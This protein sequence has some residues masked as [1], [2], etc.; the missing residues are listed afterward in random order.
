MMRRGRASFR[1]LR[2]VHADH[3]QTA[4]FSVLKL[5]ARHQSR[6]LQGLGSHTVQR[7]SCARIRLAM[8]RFPFLS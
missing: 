8:T 6:Q 1:K 7:A 3:L 2:A 5:V 4:A